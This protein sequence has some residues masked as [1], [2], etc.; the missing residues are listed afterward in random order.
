M[1]RLE[2][3]IDTADFPAAL[4]RAYGE[5]RPIS[6]DYGV[7]EKTR[8]R[9]LIPADFGWN[10]LG[11]WDEVARLFPKDESK[12]AASDNTFTR[13]VKNC[14]ISTTKGRIAAV[15][16]VED[17]IIIDTDDALLVCH[18]G[19]SQEV[20]EV[21]DYLRKKGLTQYL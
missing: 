5:M 17:M 8:D 10:D 20:K 21:V 13:D 18:K 3:A 12:N 2:E 11:S 6:I 9:F 4:E 1:Q 16:G 19:R 7:M 14:H 15:I